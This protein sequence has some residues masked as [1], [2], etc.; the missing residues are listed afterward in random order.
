MVKKL[1]LVF[2]VLLVGM[3]GLSA[4]PRGEGGA[5]DAPRIIIPQA[6]IAA[7]TAV[8]GIPEPMRPGGVFVMAQGN[9]AAFT[10]D[11]DLI[12]LWSDQY[13]EGLLSRDEFKTLVIGR[14][15]VM[16]MRDQADVTGGM[17]ALAKKTRGKVE[18][19][20]LLQELK[21]GIRKTTSLAPAEFLLLC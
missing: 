12:C 10:Q 7:F 6:D 8:P 5:V 15:A 3:T 14:I 16:Y 20:F 18:R 1:F 17:R 11:L 19:L 4:A 2:L 9:E 21:M 13:R